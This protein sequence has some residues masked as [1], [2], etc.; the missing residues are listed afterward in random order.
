M[1]GRALLAVLAICVPL[2]CGPTVPVTPS[3][4]ATSAAPSDPTATGAGSPTP[5]LTEPSAGFARW[6]AVSPSGPTPA[7]RAGQSW[8]VDPSSAVAYLFAGQDAG[9]DLSDLWAY[10]LTADAWQR[11]EP[12]G[13]RPTPRHDHS[14][15][16]IDG[17]GL[18]V[19]G[20]RTDSGVLDDF[21][22]TLG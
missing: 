20:G 16:W 11:L 4:T 15:A 2:A 6:S 12:D 8:T 14:A 1:T 19:F 3:P 10:D 18:V 22:A 9:S 7:P 21:W 5:V 17:F 13:D